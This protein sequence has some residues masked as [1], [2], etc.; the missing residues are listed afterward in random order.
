MRRSA[1]PP[2]CCGSAGVAT[3]L[4]QLR[5][6][7]LLPI[8]LL[9]SAVSA[10]AACPF[11]C[12]P[13]SQQEGLLLCLCCHYLS[14]H[15]S[16][17][18]GAQQDAVGAASH[19]LR[20]GIFRC[21]RCCRLRVGSAGNLAGSRRSG[22]RNHLHWHGLDLLRLRLQL[23]C[24][25]SRLLL[26]RH[27]I[28]LQLLNGSRLLLGRRS[29]LLRLLSGTCLL[30]SF[31]SDLLRLLSRLLLLS[32]QSVLLRLLSDR[33]GLLR[34]CL[35]GS[36]SV[37]LRLPGAGC[38]R[39]RRCGCTGGASLEASSSRTQRR[40]LLTHLPCRRQLR[41]RLRHFALL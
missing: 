13:L 12:L 33:S 26:R 4:L 36:C 23:G 20:S 1:G 41:L 38:R 22:A 19:R 32:R 21:L 7:L 40:L 2:L 25:R 16:C 37:L 35:S 14:Q 11:C 29:I 34:L 3:L 5:R 15:C 9:C 31:H 39:R 6:G 30:L 24:S 8:R 17:R 27:S 10:T 18:L 28:L